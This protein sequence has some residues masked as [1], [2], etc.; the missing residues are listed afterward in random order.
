MQLSGVE[1]TGRGSNAAW[2]LCQEHRQAHIHNI[3]EL[4][5]WSHTVLHSDYTLGYVL[6]FFSILVFDS[7]YY[8][9]NIVKPS[10]KVLSRD[11]LLCIGNMSYLT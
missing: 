1:E 11:T 6:V 7:S 8:Y 10:S 2:E 4:R 3:W 9:S 5:P